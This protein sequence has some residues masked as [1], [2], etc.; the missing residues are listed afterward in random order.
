MHQLASVKR[1][2]TIALMI[3]SYDK[4]KIKEALLPIDHG[5]VLVPTLQA[6]G[7]SVGRSVG[8]S[9]VIVFGQLGVPEAN[10][11]RVNMN[12]GP[13]RTHRPTRNYFSFPVKKRLRKIYD[14]SY[15]FKRFDIGSSTERKRTAKIWT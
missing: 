11:S 3:V 12:E 13:R 4:E 1:M 15:L 6:S 10:F 9:P 5:I 14:P 8:W 7:R 2:K